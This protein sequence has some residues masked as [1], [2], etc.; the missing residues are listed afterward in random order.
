M[1]VSKDGLQYRFVIPGT[2]LSNIP[3]PSFRGA[4]KTLARNDDGESRRGCYFKCLAKKAM[5]RGQ[6]MSALVLS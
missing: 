2:R 6:A 3:V 1:A 4:S 5:L